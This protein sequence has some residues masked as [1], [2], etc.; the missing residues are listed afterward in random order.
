MIELWDQ[1]M[2]DKLEQLIEKDNLIIFMIM[3][4]RLIRY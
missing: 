3:E 4:N 2:D 1:L